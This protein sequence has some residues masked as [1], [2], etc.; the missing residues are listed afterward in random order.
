MP[1]PVSF[2]FVARCF[3][4]PFRQALSETVTKV[5]S[6]VATVKKIQGTAGRACVK[7]ARRAT[8][9]FLFHLVACKPTFFFFGMVIT[10]SRFT[11][12]TVVQCQGCSE[13]LLSRS[14][15]C[16]S[17]ALSLS[18]SFFFFSLFFFTH[19]SWLVVKS[20]PY[21]PFISRFFFQ[22][23]RKRA[24]VTLLVALQLALLVL[25]PLGTSAFP[26]SKFCQ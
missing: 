6:H 2:F 25:G 11:L 21:L 19:V 3:C 4:V 5:P 8:A 18:F 9:P 15:S 23:M 17:A 1:A 16:S 13:D 20:F 12:E 10:F 24:L 14:S 26:G 7:A 22:S